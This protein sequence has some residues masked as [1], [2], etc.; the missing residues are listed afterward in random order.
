M[1]KN[2]DPQNQDLS[3]TEVAHIIEVDAQ[4]D[5]VEN[6]QDAM[7]EAI[8]GLLETDG[9]EFPCHLATVASNGWGSIIRYTSEGEVITLA[10]H[11]EAGG[12]MLPIH[13]VLLDTNG[14]TARLIVRA[15][16]HGN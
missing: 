3:V 9:L 16:P 12:Q 8:G 14:Y 15:K 10:E 7:T 6:I 11:E 4:T 5:T 2:T 1:R 13:G